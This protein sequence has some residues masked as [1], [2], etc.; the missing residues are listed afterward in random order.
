MYSPE[1]ALLRRI[2]QHIVP[3]EALLNVAKRE[4]TQI[5][6]MSL[7]A[8]AATKNSIWLV[9]VLPILRKAPPAHPPS[10]KFQPSLLRTDYSIQNYKKQTD[11][12]FLNTRYTEETALHLQKLLQKIAKK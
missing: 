8:F 1:D 10:F 9:R 6:E 4:A 7:N 2:I 12:A 3:K 5:P 11:D